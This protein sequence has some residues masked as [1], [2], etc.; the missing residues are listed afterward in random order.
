MTGHVS[1]A[2]RREKRDNIGNFV[3]VSG[4]AE[5]QRLGPCF[6]IGKPLCAVHVFG[7]GTHVGIDDNPRT[8]GIDADVMHAKFAGETLRQVD[9]CR[10][11]RTIGS[12]IG[13]TFFARPRG[14]IDDNA[15]TP[16][17]HSGQHCLAEKEYT[18]Q[19]DR[20][21][22]PPVIF[23]HIKK[24]GRAQYARIIHKNVDGAERS[25]KLTHR[26]HDIQL[27]RHTADVDIDLAS[28][29]AHQFCGFTHPRR[30]DVEETNI[31]SIACQPQCNFAANPCPGPGH[32]S[33]SVVEI[34]H[35]FNI[36]VD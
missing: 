4:A 19:V 30:I 21:S 24:I 22:A 2:V 9:Y 3:R 29:A 25:G 32:N 31:A 36:A 28:Q 10:F 20:K 18:I 14:H 23:A 26:G 13:H 15:P 1:S 8:D 11:G 33:N 35:F 27:N 34:G 16:L 7:F 12:V 17:D 5:W 6:D